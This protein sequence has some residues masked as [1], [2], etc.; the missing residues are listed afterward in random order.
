MDI[1][2]YTKSW[3]IYDNDFVTPFIK[4]WYPCFSL[5]F[6]WMSSAKPHDR[7]KTILLRLEMQMQTRMAALQLLLVD[8]PLLVLYQRVAQEA[9][10]M[11]QINRRNH[12]RSEILW[13]KSWCGR[14]LVV[15]HK[16]VRTWE[17]GDGST[18]AFGSVVARVGHDA[19]HRARWQLDKYIPDVSSFEGVCMNFVID[20]GLIFGKPQI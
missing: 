12:R 20:W 3:E 4:A 7:S 18:K 13:L 17:M 15:R 8:F 1:N 16:V 19:R 5:F 11:W 9:G 14:W 10:Q 2:C 6:P